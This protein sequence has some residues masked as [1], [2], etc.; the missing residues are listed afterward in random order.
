MKSKYGERVE[1]APALPRPEV[2]VHSAE[3][4]N[5]CAQATCRRNTS[6][7]LVPP[8]PNELESTTSMLRLRAWCG[9]RSIGV[10]TDGLSRL[11][12]GGAT[13]SRIARMEKIASTAP[14]APSR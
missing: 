12:V 4:T 9:T 6:D 1:E 2:R 7:A 10:S 14:A 3:N 11:S 13:L 8:K 5:E